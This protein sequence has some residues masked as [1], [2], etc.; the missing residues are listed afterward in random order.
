MFF[1]L[2]K[3]NNNKKKNPRENAFFKE[4]TIPKF[5][6]YKETQVRATQLEKEL[7]ELYICLQ[8]IYSSIK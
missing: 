5:R 8:L 7:I 1:K 4:F 2:K 3:N 6:K